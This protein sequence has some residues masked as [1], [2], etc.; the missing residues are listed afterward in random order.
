MTQLVAQQVLVVL[1]V[2]RKSECPER[3]SA[4]HKKIPDT[5]G[6][7]A[8]NQVVVECPPRLVADRHGHID[9]T[10]R[11]VGDGHKK[12]QRSAC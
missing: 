8:S 2:G 11:V 4:P 5:L 3:P 10:H 9:E 7:Q 6:D 1:H 12:R